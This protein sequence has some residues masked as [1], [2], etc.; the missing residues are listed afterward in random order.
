[1]EK[2]N[3]FGMYFG[4]EIISQNVIQ[5]KLCGIFQRINEDDEYINFGIGYNKRDN[6]NANLETQIKLK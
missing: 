5:G 1:M 2:T 4:K 3:V 6:F